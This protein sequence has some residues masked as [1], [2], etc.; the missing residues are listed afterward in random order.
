MEPI[1]Y[2]VEPPIGII[3][4]D[5]PADRNALNNEASVALLDACRAA[6]RD[7]RCRVIL[8]R[9]EGPVFCAGMDLEYLRRIMAQSHEENLQDSRRFTALFECLWSVPKP[10]VAAVQGPALGGGCGLAAICDVTVATEEATFGF[11]EVRIGFVPAIV[12]VF[13]VRLIG[14]SHARDLFMTG[15][16]IS[17]SDAHRM[18]LV[19]EVVTAAALEDRTRVIANELAGN[20]PQA[21]AAIRHVLPP[22]PPEEWERAAVANAQ[23]R[24]TEDCREGVWAFLEKRPPSWAGS[25]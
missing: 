15:R 11:P 19:N 20:S 24:M 13:V 5:R 14:Q 3:T 9:A 21:L 7:P 22:I 2:D 23:A 25:V 6:G 16:R 8:L 1:R 18:G 4:L 12:S 10:T 17:A